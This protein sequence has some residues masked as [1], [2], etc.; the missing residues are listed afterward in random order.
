MENFF[1]LSSYAIKWKLI[2]AHTFRTVP[3][4]KVVSQGFSSK[5]FT[6]NA[7]DT[8]R[9]VQSLGQ[10]YPLEEETATHSSILVWEI[11][12]QDTVHGVAKSHTWLSMHT[13]SYTHTH[14]HTHT[15]IERAQFFILLPLTNFSACIFSFPPSHLKRSTPSTL[16]SSGPCV[17]TPLFSTGYFLS[18]INPSSFSSRPC[19]SFP[20]CLSPYF[21]SSFQSQA[22]S[23]FSPT[24]HSPA[25]QN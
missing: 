22:G 20:F 6:C 23:N 24:I 18:A 17:F 1:R 9:W 19:S 14:A 3:S 25:H 10:E 4:T 2:S 15:H 13:H 11:P 7:G 8:Q 16:T 12:W 5:K 21:S